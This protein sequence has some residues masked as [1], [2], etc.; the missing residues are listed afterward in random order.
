MVWL[1]ENCKV[2]CGKVKDA[3]NL[4]NKKYK[5]NWL[6]LRGLKRKYPLT[7]NF[8]VLLS[9]SNRSLESGVLG[10]KSEGILQKLQN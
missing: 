10:R 2:K 1:A 8:V 9:I 3:H 6:P 7:R 4:A 5:T